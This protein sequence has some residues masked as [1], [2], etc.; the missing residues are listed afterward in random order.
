MSAPFRIICCFIENH[1]T[2]T[3]KL[4]MY[5]LAAE[6]LRSSLPEF[7]ASQFFPPFCSAKT[8]SPLRCHPVSEERLDLADGT[9]LAPS[10]VTGAMGEA[11]RTCTCMYAERG[12]GHEQGKTYLEG[13]NEARALDVQK[14]T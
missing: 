11:I 12:R 4:V 8:R 6:A 7:A 1:H 2:T 10:T 3:R 9:T 5:A 14:V 13:K